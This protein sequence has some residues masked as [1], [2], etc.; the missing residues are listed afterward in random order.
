MLSRADLFSFLNPPRTQL[1]PPTFPLSAQ[2]SSAFDVALRALDRLC[3]R[4]EDADGEYDA[5]ASLWDQHAAAK[6]RRAALAPAVDAAMAAQD[7]LGEVG[8]EL[9][10][11]TVDGKRY[12]V[13]LL[14]RS[15]ARRTNFEK[16]PAE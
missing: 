2:Q 4:G 14:R 15:M 1:V 6:A 10:L 8:L 11:R 12:L 9:S 5:G 13:V 3:P 7:A 16:E